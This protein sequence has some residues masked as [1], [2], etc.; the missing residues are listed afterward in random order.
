MTVR[1][2]GNQTTKK[3]RLQLDNKTTREKDYN[4]K[5]QNDSQTTRQQD[6]QYDQTIKN[7]KD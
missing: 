5:I 7:V 4:I 2:Q 3:T 6:N 1:Q